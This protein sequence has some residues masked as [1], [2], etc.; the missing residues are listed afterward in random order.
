MKKDAS[1]E[2]EMVVALGS[3]KERI[4]PESVEQ[5]INLGSEFENLTSNELQSNVT[6][7]NNSVLEQNNMKR[8]LESLTT[9]AEL[10]AND[11]ITLE[12]KNQKINEA[13]IRAGDLTANNN[14]SDWQKFLFQDLGR[15]KLI[16]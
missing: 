14:E 5:E 9:E 10:T 12:K 6:E 13:V 4:P 1:V 16:Y 3:V 11:K 15:T 7:V 2:I 8:Q